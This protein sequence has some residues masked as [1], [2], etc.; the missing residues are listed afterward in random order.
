ML[1]NHLKLST[2]VATAAATT[3][4]ASTCATKLASSTLL[5]TLASSTL[6]ATLASG[7]AMMLLARRRVTVLT[8]GASMLING[9]A[10]IGPG[11]ASSLCSCGE[12]A[13]KQHCEKKKHHGKSRETHYFLWFLFVGI[14]KQ[15]LK[16]GVNCALKNW[17]HKF[18][19]LVFRRTMYGKLENGNN[20][21][22]FL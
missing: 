22:S 8:G 13:D 18:L 15:A 17:K 3:V 9:G 10:P 20:I 7:A 1:H 21:L 11:G 19:V 12:D 6:L 4:T 14:W 5:A 16:I 2:T